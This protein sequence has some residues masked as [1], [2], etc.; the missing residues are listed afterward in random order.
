MKL[1]QK[2]N[3]FSFIEVLLSLLLLT[4]FSYWGI[5]TL[6][7][8]KQR[9]LYA[10]Q[11]I[12]ITAITEEIRRILT[13]SQNCAISFQGKRP[14]TEVG[15]INSIQRLSVF[16]GRENSQARFPTF[17]MNGQTYGEGKLKILSYELSDQAYD[18]G[19]EDRS[20]ELLIKFDRKNTAPKGK[21]TES[22]E[23]IK[24]YYLLNSSEDRQTIEVCS[25]S[26]IKEVLETW[27]TD[28]THNRLIYTSGAVGIKVDLPTSKLDINGP[29]QFGDS[30]DKQECNFELR[31]QL[32]K[33][34]TTQLVLCDGVKWINLTN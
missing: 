32:K 27:E 16:N 11:E 28:P 20:T 4:V 3:G 14:T 31:G 33:A 13:N 26:P 30:S 21:P 23:K 8:Q 17:S 9:I 5:K 18:V 10:N 1:N 7:E 25:L 22:V 34:T 19:N 6:E 12:E 2:P 29:I 24:I 15:A